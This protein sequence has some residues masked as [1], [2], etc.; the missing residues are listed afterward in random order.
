MHIRYISELMDINLLAVVF[1][2]GN[3]DDLLVV[4]C[5]I[6][7]VSSSGVIDKFLNYVQVAKLD[8]LVQ[9]LSTFNRQSA[10]P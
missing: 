9:L 6:S 7:S 4:D 8:S 3:V 5:L 2:G 10:P 1:T